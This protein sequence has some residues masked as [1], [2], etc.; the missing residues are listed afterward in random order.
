MNTDGIHFFSLL[1]VLIEPFRSAR[2]P[3]N[4]SK[5]ET[6]SRVKIDKKV[7]FQK[8]TTA[9][10][11][12]VLRRRCQSVVRRRLSGVKNRPLQRFIYN[13][14]ATAT[15]SRR[16]CVQKRTFKLKLIK[17]KTRQRIK[18]RCFVRRVRS[19]G[20]NIQCCII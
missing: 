17:K 10:N 13:T 1:Y 2:I 15:S 3:V 12:F 5:S 14:H 18:L 19:S 4:I 7:Y 11:L 16:P 20:F 8:K 6:S 9:Q